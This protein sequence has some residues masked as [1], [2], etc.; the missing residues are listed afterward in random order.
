MTNL[1]KVLRKIRSDNGETLKDMA[2]KLNV[3]ITY[4]SY[5]E[6]GERQCPLKWE[7]I[8]VSEYILC[9]KQ[10]EELKQSIAES[11]NKIKINID[12]LCE[13]KKSLTV[14]FLRKIPMLS[15]KKITQI[16]ALLKEE[17]QSVGTNY[18]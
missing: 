8:I 17:N 12:E 7:S 10:V 13:N 15:C 6:T 5:V 14:D 2:A 1:G 4:L 9:E 16:E 18:G 11:I 3:S